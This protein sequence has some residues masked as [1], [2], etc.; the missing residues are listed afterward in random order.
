MQWSRK[1]KASLLCFVSLFILSLVFY[2]VSANY[3]ETG[4]IVRFGNAELG[5]TSEPRLVNEEYERI[6]SESRRNQ[7]HLEY[8]EQPK[9]QFIEIKRWFLEQD[10]GQIVDQMNSLLKN[11]IAAWQISVN[12]EQVGMVEHK[13]SADKLLHDLK[14]AY[15]EY[16]SEEASFMEKVSV[17]KVRTV[18][19]VLSNIEE[20]RNELQRTVT[21]A[22]VH[23]VTE[24]ETIWGIAN[25]HSVEMEEILA[26][27]PD[28]KEA[29]K[30]SDTIMISPEIR[31]VNVL[32]K[33]T[34]IH[35]IAIP[36]GIEQLPYLSNVKSRDGQAGKK[37]VSYLVEK[38][39]GIEIKREIV[40]EDIIEKPVSKIVIEKRPELQVASSLRSSKQSS[41]NPAS[42]VLSW[43]TDGGII[44]SK[45]GMRN[46]KMH[47]G[48]DIA[49]AESLN[50][51][52]AAS[53]KVTFVGSKG[54]YGNLIM[55]SHDNGLTTYYAHIKESLV[56]SGD[57]VT[58]GEIIA[59]MGETGNA[60]GVSLHF[61]V[62][63]DNKA[64]NP[65]NY[66]S[67]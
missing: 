41:R 37:K 15:G 65:L 27:N 39:N 28:T 33:E 17:E 20:L 1:R 25:Q 29:I 61:E 16:S 32:T 58:A 42:S 49:G 64:N 40:S 53:G 26:L 63:R 30:P 47:R 8:V 23:L 11:E 38:M 51:K 57:V 13:S 21:P 36:F 54:N 48:I 6:L 52:A 18:P 50:I 9:P 19:N 43:P 56:S 67:S 12:G 44:T 7:E 55:I 45:Y 3:Y 31:K 46:G 10:N 5:I 62:R 66:V 34:L 4:Y 35:N 59:I 14:S 60:T 24:G 2:G 22:T